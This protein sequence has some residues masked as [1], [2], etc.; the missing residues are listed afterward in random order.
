ME[1]PEVKAKAGDRLALWGGINTH[2][3]I[4]A[5]T[6]DDVREEAGYIFNRTD[7]LL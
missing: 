3:V 5:G 1:S 2:Q 6:P 7:H 4:P